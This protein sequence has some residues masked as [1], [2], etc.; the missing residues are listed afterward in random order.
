[1]LIPYNIGGSTFLEWYETFIEIKKI[2][3]W[4]DVPEK[5]RKIKEKIFEMIIFIRNIY[6]KVYHFVM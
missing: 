3:L 1:M 5:Y 2:Y 4:N 6:R